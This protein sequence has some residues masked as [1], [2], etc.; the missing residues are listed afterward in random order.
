MA[1]AVITGE[2]QRLLERAVSKMNELDYRLSAAEEREKR[3]RR[4]A[5]ARADAARYLTSREH[6]L[7]MQ[8][9]AR[10][11]QAR[12]DDALTPWGVRAPAFV[13]DEDLDSYRRRLARIAQR[14]L[15]DDHELRSFKLRSLPDEAFATFEPQIYDAVKKAGTQPDSVPPDETREVVKVNP[16]NGQ[17]TIE[18]IGTRSFV[19]DFKSPIRFV[20]GFRSGLGYITTTGRYLR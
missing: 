7:E 4:E 11:Y 8:A 15:P 18:F 12:C 3:E 5:Q 19:H 10:R 1:T 9:T 13:A 14:Q 16:A 20:R 6:L 17:K 2:T